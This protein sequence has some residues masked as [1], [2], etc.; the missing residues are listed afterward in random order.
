MQNYIASMKSEY[1]QYFCDAKNQLENN[2]LRTI[3]NHITNY[4]DI[5]ELLGFQHYL[6]VQFTT[7]YNKT[8]GIELQ[9]KN[10]AGVSAHLLFYY[11]VQSFESALYSLECNLI[12]SSASNLRTVQEAIPKMYYISL[13]L[14]RNRPDRNIPTVAG[15]TCKADGIT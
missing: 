6:D 11:N 5:E 15:H 7:F 14:M 8:T 13:D 9:D 2:R 1:L 4:E 12:H 3:K 10:M